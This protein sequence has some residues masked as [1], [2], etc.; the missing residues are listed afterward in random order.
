V[1][2]PGTDDVT[3]PGSLSL[4]PHP[5]GPRPGTPGATSPLLE[6]RPQALQIE[7]QPPPPA[8]ARSLRLPAGQPATIVTI[9]FDDPERSRPGGL[10]DLVVRSDMVRG[11]PPV[12]AGAPPDGGRGNLARRRAPPLGGREP[13][14]RYAGAPPRPPNPAA[15]PPAVPRPPPPAARGRV[16]SR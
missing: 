13:L 2:A 1:A 9:R 11:G 16:S 8:V 3:L 4:L 14:P 12:A 6:A 10:D 7:V 5:D 15:A